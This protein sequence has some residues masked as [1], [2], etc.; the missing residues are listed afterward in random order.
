MK[1]YSIQVGCASLQEKRH[2]H[3]TNSHEV[4]ETDPYKPRNAKDYQHHQKLGKDK[5]RFSPG[6][7]GG[8]MALLT[9]CFQ[10]SELCKDKFL[11]FEVTHLI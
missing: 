10:T 5:E 4:W 6:A 11:L 3:R 2:T 7:F 1:S 9:P 8:S